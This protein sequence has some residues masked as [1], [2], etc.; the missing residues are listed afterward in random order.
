MSNYKKKSKNNH[1]K[2]KARKDNQRKYRILLDTEYTKKCDNYV[3]ISFT[4]ELCKK[5]TIA[6]QIEQYAK[7]IAFWEKEFAKIIP[8][9]TDN[10][11]IKI[12]FVS[13]AKNEIIKKTHDTFPE[14]IVLKIMNRVSQLLDTVRCTEIDQIRID[15]ETKYNTGIKLY[16]KLVN[17]VDDAHKEKILDPANWI[18]NQSTMRSTWEKMRSEF[19]KT[20][21]GEL[22]NLNELLIEY[23]IFMYDSYPPNYYNKMIEC[24]DG[25]YCDGAEVYYD[26]THL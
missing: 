2:N 19:E 7:N 11:K 14:E 18:L 15:L 13:D 22:T 17:N 10:T 4:D 9:D 8:D 20:D 16:K 23:M 25:G 26:L 24:K 5:F 3:G 21:S 12:A 1:N 6:Q